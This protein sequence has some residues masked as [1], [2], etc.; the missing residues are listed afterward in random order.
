MYTHGCQI[1]NRSRRNKLKE[2]ASSLAGMPFFMPC[3][4]ST[5]TMCITS[6]I[7]Y[8]TFAV[9]AVTL[10]CLCEFGFKNEPNTCISTYT[11]T[12]T[13]L[14]HTLY[15]ELLCCH[16]SEALRANFDCR[17]DTNGLQKNGSLFCSVPFGSGLSVCMHACIC[18]CSFFFLFR[19][20]QKKV[21]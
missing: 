4:Q 7:V 21:L 11:R 6:Y 13:H 5:I 3:K 9:T 8:Y 12:R 10:C 1:R 19:C 17:Y 18:V 16:L 15:S 2:T 14:Q 20:F